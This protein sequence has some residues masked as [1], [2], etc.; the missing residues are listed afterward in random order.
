MGTCV[1]SVLLSDEQCLLDPPSSPAVSAAHCTSLISPFRLLCSGTRSA[2][3]NSH[4]FSIK[5]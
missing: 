5:P 4:E 2:H 1:G 3:V